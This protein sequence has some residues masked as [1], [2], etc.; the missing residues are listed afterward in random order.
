MTIEK[1]ILF[2][3]L[4]TLILSNGKA[5]EMTVN[6][7]THMLMSNDKLNKHAD[8]HAPKNS[9]LKFSSNGYVFT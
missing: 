6:C 9:Q 1:I 5:I 4:K 3:F 7:Q 2:R 8:T